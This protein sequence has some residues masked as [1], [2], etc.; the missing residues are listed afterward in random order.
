[1]RRAAGVIAA[2]LLAFA[3]WNYYRASRAEGDARNAVRGDGEVPFTQQTLNNPP[4]AG[5]ETLAS[6]HATNAFRRH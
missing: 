4:P 1:M 5:W 2:L 3:G 6:I